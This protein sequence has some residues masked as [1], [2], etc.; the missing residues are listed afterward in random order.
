LDMVFVTVS[1]IDFSDRI[2]RMSAISNWCT[3]IACLKSMVMFAHATIELG[4]AYVVYRKCQRKP[5]I[6][7]GRW[8]WKML[9]TVFLQS[10]V[11]LCF[12]A[13]SSSIQDAGAGPNTIMSTEDL[14]MERRCM[15]T[16]PGI[17][18]LVM[19]WALLGISLVLLLP[20]FYFYI[21]ASWSLY[22]TREGSRGH[23]SSVGDEDSSGA[24]VDSESKHHAATTD[25]DTTL[26]SEWTLEQLAACLN[27]PAITTT[28]QTAQNSKD[29]LREGVLRR[30]Q[31][32]LLVCIIVW[33]PTI[34]SFTLVQFDAATDASDG[35]GSIMI[36][37]SGSFLSMTYA[38]N[39]WQQRRY[40]Q[41]QR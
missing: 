33:V 15:H 11:I 7:L 3:I 6:N 17:Q 24:N 22:R 41:R 13:L 21:L 1:L 19:K 39:V 35:I 4:V 25:C 36:M 2:S 27:E 40:E 5:D 9:L 20:M 30:M 23:H 26:A 38:W 8:E 34:T 37:S 29:Q 10:I 32:Y 12:I 16:S 14:E 18:R 28:N 31:L